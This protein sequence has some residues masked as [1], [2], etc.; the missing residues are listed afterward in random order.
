MLNSRDKL[1]EELRMA[2]ELLS[3]HNDDWMEVKILLIR[4]LPP[5]LR[6]D[7]SSKDSSNGK[8]YLNEF[9][10]EIVGMYYRMTGVKLRIK[11]NE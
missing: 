9:E 7:F 4:Y 8:S 2:S 10:Q 6:A 11:D 1:L 5:A 3:D